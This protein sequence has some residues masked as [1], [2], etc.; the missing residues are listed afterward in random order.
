MVSDNI[1][2]VHGIPGDK[3]NFLCKMGQDN[4]RPTFA[5]ISEMLKVPGGTP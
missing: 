3:E 5:S 2:P 4:L 1:S